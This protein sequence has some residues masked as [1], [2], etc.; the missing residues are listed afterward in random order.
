MDGY[1]RRGLSLSEMKQIL[2]NVYVAQED[3]V[4]NDKIY[5]YLFETAYNK[6]FGYGD[7]LFSRERGF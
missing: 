7:G 4:V 1:K 6:L 5:G 2:N 3:H